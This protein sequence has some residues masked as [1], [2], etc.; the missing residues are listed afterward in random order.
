MKLFQFVLFSFL[1]PSYLLFLV[2]C[3]NV[4]SPRNGQTNAL[5][6]MKLYIF[7]GASKTT[8]RNNYIAINDV[9]YLDLSNSSLFNTAIPTWHKDAEM[10]VG[11]YGAS[12]I[13]TF[14]TT[15]FIWSSISVN[16]S[17][18]ESRWGHS[19]VLGQNG[20]IIIYGGSKY[21]L[22]Q[23][24][25][26]L[27]NLAVL[28]TN[29]WTWSIPDIPST[30]TPQPLLFHSAAL[31]KNYKFWLL[32]SFALRLLNLFNNYIQIGW[33][34]STGDLFNKEVYV[35]DTQKYVWI[36]VNNTATS[37]KGSSTSQKIQTNKA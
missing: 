4:P 27:P 13:R 25:Q 9:W 23:D 5:V 34:A 19:A 33:I 2:N 7:G 26:A 24:I 11:I 29:S 17:S 15:S 35:L 36:A 10:P 6:G 20:E 18:I 12:C 22:S 14:N 28:S 21:N 30:N 1:L 3:L 32:C 8:G 37:T 31:Y 16:G